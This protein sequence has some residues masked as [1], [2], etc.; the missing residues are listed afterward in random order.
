MNKRERES[1]QAY[2]LR[3][4][5]DNEKSPWRAMLESTHTGCRHNFADVE[6]LISFLLAE[7]EVSK[8]L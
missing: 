2:L 4:W 3:I 5:R 7:T 8:R 6:Q 1:Y